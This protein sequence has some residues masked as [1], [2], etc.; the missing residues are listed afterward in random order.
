MGIDVA[1]AAGWLSQSVNMEKRGDFFFKNLHASA[2]GY[3]RLGKNGLDGLT[4]F[5]D[6][7]EELEL[8]F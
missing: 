2:A 8:S 1:E 5:L 3:R 7:R 6:R 4:T